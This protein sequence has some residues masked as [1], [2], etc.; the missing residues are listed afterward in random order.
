[1]DEER[2]EK[3]N[4]FLKWLLLR[5]DFLRSVIKDKVSIMHSDDGEKWM[6][7]YRTRWVSVNFLILRLSV[8]IAYFLEFFSRYSRTMCVLIA[9]DLKMFGSGNKINL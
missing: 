3:M 5:R 7:K 6:W 2:A 1:M 8:L 9:L 4:C